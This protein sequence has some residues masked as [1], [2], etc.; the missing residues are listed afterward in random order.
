MQVFFKLLS[1]GIIER[2]DCG[3]FK[4]SIHTLHLSICPRMFNF[5]LAM[6]NMMLTADTIK[7]MNKSISMMIMMG[8]LN[9]IVGEY[10]M[11]FIWDSFNQVTQKRCDNHF[12]LAV[13]KLCIGKL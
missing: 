9:P 10:F 1:R 6:F 11:D 2:V 5:S 3:V 12:R 13:M 7:N 4:G 8:E